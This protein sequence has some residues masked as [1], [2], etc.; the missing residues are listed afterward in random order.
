ME[1]AWITILV[2]IFILSLI[3]AWKLL[4]WLWLTPKRLE[5]LLRE[6]GLQ[7][8]PY[9]LL[10]GDSMEVI[11]IRKEA[12]SKPITLF[13]HDI[14]PRVSS[15]AQHTLNKHGKN[16]FIW[17]GPIPRVT[18]TDPELIKENMLPLFIKCCDDLISK[19][20]GML[21]SDGSS[22]INV[23][24]FLQN[25]ASDAISRTAFGSSYEEGRRIF[26]LLKE[27]T[28]LTMKI[29]LKV[30]IPG[31]RFVPTT[32]HRRIKEID[33]V[34]KALLM[35]MINK[36]E[37]ALKA[38]EATKNN[39]LDILLESNHKEIQEHKNNKNV[40]LNLEEVIQECK[41]F[42]FA[43]QETTSVLLVWTMILLSRYP[44]WQTRA[45]EE[46]LKVFG[47]QKPNFDGLS[48]LK[49]VTMILYE[50]LRLY[51]PAIGLVRKVNKDVKLGNL[52]LPAGVQ[53]SLPIVLVHHDCE[54]WGDDA[55]EFK[56]ERFSEGL[57]KAT[58]GRFSFFAFGGG[59]RICIG[60]NFSFLE[61]KI[62]LSM[63]LQ[64]FLF[65]LSPTYT[66]A[67]TTVITLQPQYGAHLILRKYLLLSLFHDSSTFS[68][69][70]EMEAASWPTII[71]LL[72]IL[73]WAWKM[74][75]W[76]WLRPKRLERLLR[77]QGLQGNSYT[78]FVGDLKE[79]GK[80][81]NEALS[82]PMNLFSHDIAPRVLSFIQHTV[83]KHGKN[84]FIWFGPIPRVT[85]TDPEQIKDVLN[86][87]YDFGK[88]D[89]NPHVR[90]LAPGLVSH[91]GEKWS[92]H[93]KIINPAFNLEKLKN[94]LPL[95]IKCCDDLISKWEGMLSSDGTSE[96]DIWP[97][98]QNLASDVISRTAF[99]SSYEEGRRIF[100][101][102]KEQTELT[103]QTFLKVNIPGWRR[104]KEI[105]KD[106][107]ASLMD[108]INKRETALK[109]GEATKNNLLDILLESNHKEIQ[110]QG[111]KNVGM[112]LEEVIEEC[113]LFYFAG[114]ETTSVL[115]VW[116]MILLSMYPDWQTRAREEVL[117]VFG[118]RKPNF[119]GLNHLKIVTMIL[120]EVLRLYPPVVGLARK[121]NE[122]VKLGNLSLPAGVQISLPIVLVH[123][124]C[125]L[126]GDDAKEFKPERFSEGLLKATNGRVSFFAFGGGPRICI[127]QNFSFLEAK[128]ALSM[129]LQRFSFELSPTYTHAPTSVITLQPQHGA[130]LI[131]HKVEI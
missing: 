102:L 126:W 32:T 25:L 22:E 54:L 28:E 89:M 4:N 27:Q 26:Q 60:Q 121:V 47:N 71:L 45:R 13:S 11:K 48:H 79:F 104:M 42:Y 85:L 118:N 119:E 64:R 61:A 78:L 94:M 122:D 63:I 57:L 117:Q 49:I 80:M 96:T 99:G 35:D 19:W 86:K 107:E 114:Q 55:K 37:K 7:G 33:R 116:T 5:R 127:G 103:I 90:L 93:R 124:D 125:E 31:W 73:I 1:A 83:N 12:L 8:N 20:E 92:K 111:N 10:V 24:P 109:A 40:G 62:A 69:E 46:V 65:E 29:I 43:G 15:Y 23:W 75:N 97:F 131:L 123:H 52:S 50:V 91:E 72:I 129:I 38:D 41:L 101:L 130:H 110:E 108:M 95:F 88:P 84:S 3:G 113:K 36:R 6:Q 100:Q 105:N 39:L 128:I 81:R 59:P 9:T 77:E 2:L 58:N 34:I 66:H 76:L 68:T 70:R 17:F 56:P 98:F 87:I 30:Y 115:L 82:K 106:I 53:I 67:P 21:S 120:N 18:L 74:L 44:D 112:N 14:V 16:S 51:P